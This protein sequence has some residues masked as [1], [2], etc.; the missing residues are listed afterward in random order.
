M[1]ENQEHTH[2]AFLHYCQPLLAFSDPVYPVDGGIVILRETVVIIEMFQHGIMM[3]AQA[4]VKHSSTK[5]LLLNV[6]H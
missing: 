6:Y 3:I 1:Y 2:L 5:F 4:T